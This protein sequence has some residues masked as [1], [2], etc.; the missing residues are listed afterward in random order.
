MHLMVI[1]MMI[2]RIGH[3]DAAA[4]EGRDDSGNHNMI[5]HFLSCAYPCDRFQMP[6][7]GAPPLR[8]ANQRP[9]TA[10]VPLFGYGERSG[11]IVSRHRKAH[12]ALEKRI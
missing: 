8:S 9:E 1:V 11:G 6:R 4:K 7:S 12:I 3:G 5:L 10:F 2:A